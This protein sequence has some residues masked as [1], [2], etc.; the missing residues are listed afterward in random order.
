MRLS[1]II[2]ALLAF[3]VCGLSGCLGNPCGKGP[4]DPD[5]IVGRIGKVAIYNAPKAPNS[6]EAIALGET[7]AAHDF[8][9]ELRLEPKDGSA[10]LSLIHI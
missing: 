1:T 9:I 2:F 5:H 7:I 6:I 3:T 4:E 8:I 10:S